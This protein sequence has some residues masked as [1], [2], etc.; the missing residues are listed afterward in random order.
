MVIYNITE[1]L[2]EFMAGMDPTLNRDRIDELELKAEQLQ[3]ENKYKESLDA[4]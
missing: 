3:R 1:Y 2:I 4:Y